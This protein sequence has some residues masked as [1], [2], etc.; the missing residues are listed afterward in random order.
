[1]DL[2]MR[3]DEKGKFFTPRVAKDTL[4]AF[5][6]TDDQIIIGHVYVRPDKRLKDDLNEDASRF[7]PVTDARVYDAASESLLYH[8]SFLLIAYAHI[9]ML[10]PLEALADIRPVPWHEAA[11]EQPA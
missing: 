6:R 7:L 5:I 4:A 8:S 9:I 10:S 11:K 1:M 3:F 2:D